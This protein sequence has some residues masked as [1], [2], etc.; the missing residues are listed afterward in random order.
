MKGIKGEKDRVVT[1]S[2]IHSVIILLTLES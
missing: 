2:D 1:N